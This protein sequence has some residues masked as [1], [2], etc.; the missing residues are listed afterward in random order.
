MITLS[1]CFSY[2]RKTKIAAIYLK[3]VLINI[4]NDSRLKASKIAYISVSCEMQ[5]KHREFIE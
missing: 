2:N 4:L 3:I 5:E 1:F